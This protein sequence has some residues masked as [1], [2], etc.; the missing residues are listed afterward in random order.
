MIVYCIRNKVNGKC[1]IG[2]TIRTLRR[3]WF[4]H[5]WQ[6]ESGHK[7]ALHRAIRKYGVAS[8]A[9]YPLQTEL[10][11]EQAA[12]DAEKEFITFF[13]TTDRRYGYNQTLGGDG[14]S[15]MRR[16]EETRSR[17]S[18]V[19]KAKVF[20]EETRAK[21]SAAAKLRGYSP[22]KGTSLS[23]E[24][25]KKISESRKGKKASDEARKSISLAKKGKPWSEERRA[26]YERR[27][28]NVPTTEEMVA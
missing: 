11:D 2:K 15:G 28:N 16:S 21:L 3:R 18:E 13:M 1:Y 17:L 6:A 19:G 22:T 9:A 27:R 26:A 4:E 12:F 5:R 23:D 14:V 8:F 24:T 7:T 20:S 10:P 25:R